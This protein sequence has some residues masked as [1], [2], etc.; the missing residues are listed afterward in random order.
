FRNFESSFTITSSTISN[1]SQEPEFTTSSS[2]T[3][4]SDQSIS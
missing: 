2:T 4:D 3:S 1:N